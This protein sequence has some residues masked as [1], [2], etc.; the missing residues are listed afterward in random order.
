MP[1]DSINIFKCNMLDG[2]MDFPIVSFA[3]G[4]FSISDNFYYAQFLRYYYLAPTNKNEDNCY[5]PEKAADDK[6]D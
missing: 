2:Y 3:G 4:K 5:Q 1:D 6:I